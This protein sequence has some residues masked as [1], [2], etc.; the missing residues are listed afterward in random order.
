MILICACEV[1]G[2]ILGPGLFRHRSVL[3]FFQ[4]VSHVLYV[5]PISYYLVQEKQKIEISFKQCCIE[6]LESRNSFLIRKG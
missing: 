1:N 3:P 6:R 4:C 2:S 5:E